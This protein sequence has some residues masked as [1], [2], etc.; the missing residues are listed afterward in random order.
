MLETL[1]DIYVDVLKRQLDI[2]VWRY[3]ERSGLGYK[4]GSHVIDN[5]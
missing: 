1:L 3:K 2:W 5:N 4:F